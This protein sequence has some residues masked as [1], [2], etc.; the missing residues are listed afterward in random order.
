MLLMIKQ[1]MNFMLSI[2]L[3]QTIL[4]WKEKMEDKKLMLK[5]SNIFTSLKTD[6]NSILLFE[7]KIDERL[8]KKFKNP[9]NMLKTL[10]C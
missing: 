10:S 9:K 7:E 1:M 3:V 2:L 8:L 6:Q 4:L 5:G